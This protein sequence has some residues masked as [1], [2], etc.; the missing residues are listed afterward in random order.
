MTRKT[1]T[2]DTPTLRRSKRNRQKGSTAVE[3]AFL[4]PWIFFLFIGTLD[5]G[6]YGY[7]AINVQNAARV[8]AMT[9]SASSSTAGDS[10]VACTQALAEMASVTNLQG[11]ASCGSLPLMVTATA[12][13]AAQSADGAAAAS[14]VAVTYQT[15]TLIPFPGLTGQL[16][17]TRT[18]EMRVRD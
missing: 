8:A 11:L 4:M 6:F 16:T 18:A 1:T 12:L 9:T 17:L 14:K 3:T 7:A 2:A 10:S 5:V 15:P 13:T